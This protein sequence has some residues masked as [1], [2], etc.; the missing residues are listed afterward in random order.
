[1]K[2]IVTRIEHLSPCDEP[3]CF[4]IGPERTDYMLEPIDCTLEAFLAELFTSDRSFDF[5]GIEGGMTDLGGT[6][7]ELEEGTVIEIDPSHG[8]SLVQPAVESAEE[9]EL[10][11]KERIDLSC[12]LAKEEI[13]VMVRAAH[14]ALGTYA[15]S[16]MAAQEPSGFTEENGFY[17]CPF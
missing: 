2:A 15:Y 4:Y 16:I 5:H 17:D 14:V 1:M 3:D 12:A 8:V 11:L 10:S 6:H 9:V 7:L 13:A